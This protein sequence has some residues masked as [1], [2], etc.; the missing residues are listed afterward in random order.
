MNIFCIIVHF[1][2]QETTDRLIRQ[3]LAGSRIPDRILVI[4]NTSDNRGYAAGINRGIREL[5][6]SGGQDQDVILCCNNDLQVSRTTIAQLHQWWLTQAPLTLAAHQLGWVNLLT[7]RSYIGR[8]PHLPAWCVWPYLHG[9][10]FGGTLAAFRQLGDLPE[11]YFLYWEDVA[12]SNQARQRGITLKQF[13]DAGI[14]HD[15][16]V[17]AL[18]AS[19]LYYLVRNGAALL[20][21][22]TPHWWSVYWQLANNVR[23]FYHRWRGHESIVQ[24]LNDRKKL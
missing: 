11:A 16:S 2:L 5:V 4:D 10:C 12:T 24:A 17:G 9:S 20:E 15:D 23:V 18:T 22:A 21:T 6:L 8:K 13:P 7:G 14:T 1:G 19:Q 3:L